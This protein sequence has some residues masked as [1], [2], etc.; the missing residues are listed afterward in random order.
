MVRS[1]SPS[2]DALVWHDWFA[3]QRVA[4]PA[5]GDDPIDEYPAP[6]S[7]L[8]RA[9]LSTLRRDPS[10]AGERDKTR[11]LAEGTT[12]ALMERFTLGATALTEGHPNR[13]GAPVARHPPAARP[14][15]TSPMCPA[16][17]PGE[18]GSARAATSTAGAPRLPRASEHR[19]LLL[20]RVVS[21]SYR[22]ATTSARGP[23]AL[24]AR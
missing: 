14:R 1:L 17:R 3:T 24:Y 4:A 23:V 6:R 22:R 18:T 21:T 7:G 5:E 8:V 12:P 2:S 20:A 9:L 13:P 16:S 11:A 15:T 10:S 19:P